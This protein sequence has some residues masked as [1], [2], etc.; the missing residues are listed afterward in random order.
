MSAENYKDLI[1]GYTKM[2][3]KE[4]RMA[5]RFIDEFFTSNQIIFLNQFLKEKM[6]TELMVEE[7]S[8][9][10][11]FQGTDEEEYNI[12]NCI[13]DA[14][15]SPETWTISLN[16]LDI[17]DL[18]FAVKGIHLPNG[19]SNEILDKIVACKSSPNKMINGDQF[20]EETMQQMLS[21]ALAAGRVKML[22]GASLQD[23]LGSLAA[24]RVRFVAVND[25][26]ELDIK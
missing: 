8:F 15:N 26:A 2:L 3:T 21:E 23:V 7:Y 11:N 17:Y 16:K 18:T 12:P 14:E 24:G 9:P 22:G 13:S 5:E 6:G 1:K 19:S 4:K 25:P 10:I 20:H